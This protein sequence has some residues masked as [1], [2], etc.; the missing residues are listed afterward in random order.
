MRIGAA[1]EPWALW[2]AMPLE[3]GL[4]GQVVASSARGLVCA[5]SLGPRLS[6]LLP[7]LSPPLASREFLP[8]PMTLQVPLNS[9]PSYTGYQAEVWGSEPPRTGAMSWMT[10]GP[11]LPVGSQLLS[12]GCFW[13]RYIVPVSHRK[14][15]QGPPFNVIQEASPAL[16]QAST[17]CH[18][19]V[20]SVAILITCHL[21]QPRVPT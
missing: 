2:W 15:L 5:R 1:P 14:S 17:F 8:L 4:L 11:V 9:W 3:T 19:P 20:Q 10:L 12:Q 6:S 7:I 16:S 18:A 13:A 21:W